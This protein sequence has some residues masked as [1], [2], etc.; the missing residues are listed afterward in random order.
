MVKQFIEA[1]DNNALP[2]RRDMFTR[3]SVRV[4][5]VNSTALTVVLQDF[6][7]MAFSQGHLIYRPI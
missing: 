6:P 4:V 5:D 7:Q 2:G 3:G 1:Q